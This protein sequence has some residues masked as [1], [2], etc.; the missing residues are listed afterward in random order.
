MEQIFSSL[1]HFAKDYSAPIGILLGMM[2]F[3]GLSR[4][5]R[6]TEAHA[7]VEAPAREC[8]HCTDCRGGRSYT[9]LSCHL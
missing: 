9:G 4:M 5:M 7:H 2:A 1:M 3:D 8:P 6:R